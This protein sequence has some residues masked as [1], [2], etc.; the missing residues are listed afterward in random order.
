MRKYEVE[1]RVF[2]DMVRDILEV[3]RIDIEEISLFLNWLDNS[4]VC[5]VE[6]RLD[7]EMKIKEY[8]R[9]IIREYGECERNSWLDGCYVNKISLSD[10]WKNFYEV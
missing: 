3:E 9:M 10:I 1:K 7:S 8:L 2:L 4:N 6:I 5:V